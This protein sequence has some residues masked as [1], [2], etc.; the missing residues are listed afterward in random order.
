MRS[1][2]SGEDLAKQFAAQG[3]DPAHS[4]P[5][6]AAALLKSE[7]GKWGPVVKATGAKPG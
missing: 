5:E 7:I 4:G 3:L 1:M 2:A 6:Q